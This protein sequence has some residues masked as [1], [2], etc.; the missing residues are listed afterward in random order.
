MAP[1]ARFLSPI[2]PARHLKAVRP[3]VVQAVL[4][5]PCP[6]R[7]GDY[8]EPS[9]CDFT[10]FEQTGRV[11]DWTHTIP[12]GR[13]TVRKAKL[14]NHVV[15][16]GE[17][18]F[19]ASDA[20][21]GRD[22]DLSIRDHLGRF[23]G[24][25]YAK[26]DCRRAADHARA[27]VESD[28]ATGVSLE[29]TLR[30]GFYRKLAETGPAGR[31][32]L[33]VYK[34]DV[35]RY[36]HAMEPVNPNART[37]IP[38]RFEKAVRLAETGRLP[39]GEPLSPFIL[40]PLR[41]F[42]AFPRSPLVVGGWVGEAD[43]DARRK[44][45]DETA[46]MD[47]PADA[48]PPADE[49]TGAD[50]TPTAQAAYTLAQ[51][52]SDLSAAVGDMLSKGEH[53]KGR[54]KVKKLLDK[55]AGLADEAAAVAEMVEGDVADEPADDEPAADEESDD[56][57]DDTDTYEE[58]GEADDEERKPA[59]EPPAPKLA[60]AA[61]GRIVTKSGFKAKRFALSDV[62]EL[63]AVPVQK[64]EPRKLT[65]AEKARKQAIADLNKQLARIEAHYL[66]AK[67]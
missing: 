58:S 45:M 30:K 46:L 61:D 8:V 11:V 5:W 44:A 19:F 25:R 38:D 53:V 47:P 29:F 26:A 43:P 66:T 27:L 42:K 63:P 35:H 60:K 9:G 48:A 16:V 18:T 67:Q 14:D 49:P 51:G 36:A 12:I 54:Q 17:T 31:P 55:L 59:D 32:P 24:R 40:E 41:I 23:T 3:G 15:P 34:C 39:G 22:I 13:G 50:T 2:T 56:D 64:A 33:A 65:K 62:Q 57:A 10:P 28:Q 21:I 7:E 20:D 4:T 6:D 1:A 52:L 37:L